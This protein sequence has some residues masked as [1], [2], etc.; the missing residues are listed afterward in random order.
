MGAGRGDAK[1]WDEF[2]GEDLIVLPSDV[3]TCHIFVASF[4]VGCVVCDVVII[5]WIGKRLGVSPC[6]DGALA[7]I[8]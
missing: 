1:A 6:F 5:R 3:K 8:K 7:F 2:G 4:F